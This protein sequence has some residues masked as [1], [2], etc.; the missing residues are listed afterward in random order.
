MSTQ[1]FGEFY[2]VLDRHRKTSTI[3][4]F[5][6]RGNCHRLG[7]YFF[8]MLESNLVSISSTHNG[9]AARDNKANFWVK[10]LKNSDFCTTLG[11]CTDQGVAIVIGW[12][13]GY[14]FRSNV[15]HFLRWANS[16]MKMGIELRIHKFMDL[17]SNHAFRLAEAE[18]YF[19]DANLQEA[20]CN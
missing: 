15:H 9:V 8:S 12:N 18:G 13:Q 6:F 19:V 5:I 17:T 16:P 2:F 4:G 3:F 14:E 11:H 10:H 7:T 20:H 1:Y